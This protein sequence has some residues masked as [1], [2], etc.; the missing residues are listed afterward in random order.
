NI[1]GIQ[2]SKYLYDST[3]IMNLNEKPK[4]L[5]IVGGGYISLEFASMFANF[6]TEVTVLEMKERLMPKEDEEIVSH[7]IKDLEDKGVK[8]ELDIQTSAF[9][10]Q[11]DHT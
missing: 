9:E 11:D 7:A 8:I 3:G 5:V 2:K 4:R 1:Q 6:G 10:D